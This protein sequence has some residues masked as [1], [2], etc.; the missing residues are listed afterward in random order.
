MLA[1]FNLKFLVRTLKRA[2]SAPHNYLVRMNSDLY[3]IESRFN[4]YWYVS[5]DYTDLHFHVVAIEDRR[6]FFHYGVDT[7]SII[8]NLVRM[9]TFRDHGGASTIEMQL[10]RTITNYK[11]KKLSRKINEAILAIAI[12]RRYSK[13]EILN[14]YLNYAYF[15][16]YMNGVNEAI[17]YMYNKDYVSDLTIFESS[18]IAAMLQQP[19]PKNPTI[20]RELLLIRRAVNTQRRAFKI[21]ESFDKCN[22]TREW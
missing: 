18:M 17:K 3:T 21:K 9:I 22:I 7:R 5:Y 20:K 10:V 15:G 14:C 13:L 8:R 11:E 6:F 12:S 19:R 1:F 2:I 4:D 16:A